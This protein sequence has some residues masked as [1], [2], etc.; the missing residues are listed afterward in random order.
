MERYNKIISFLIMFFLIVS[1][2]LNTEKK[3]KTNNDFYNY[4]RDGDISIIPLR[5]PYKLY[6]ADEYVWFMDFK[7]DTSINKNKIDGVDS[8]GLSDD[9]I[10]AYCSNTYIVNDGMMPMWF[11]A[12]IKSKKEIILLNKRE[13]DSFLLEK[14]IRGIVLYSPRDIFSSFNKTGLLPW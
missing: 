11:I 6:S 2:K 4:G 1:C 10:I 12:D 3:N 9:F 13:Y 8:I 14:D 7:F 5:Q